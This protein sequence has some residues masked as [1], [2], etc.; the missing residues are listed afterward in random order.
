MMQATGAFE[1]ELVDGTFEACVEH[2]G[3]DADGPC[4]ECGWLS[5]DHTAGLAVVIEVARIPAPALRRA[6]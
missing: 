1:L 6:S 4:G 3:P 5:A 2:R